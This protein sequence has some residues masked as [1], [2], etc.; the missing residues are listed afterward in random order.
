MQL[1][2]GKCPDIE[3]SGG[4]IHS[5]GITHVRNKF[6]STAVY[7][8]AI[9]LVMNKN[10]EFYDIFNSEIEIKRNLIHRHI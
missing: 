4:K 8:S 1:Y 5:M 9:S 3:G 6:L 7:E 2:A 10:K